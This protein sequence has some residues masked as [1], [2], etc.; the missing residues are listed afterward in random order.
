[1]H[2]RWHTL[3]TG[4][5]LF[6]FEYTPDSAKGI[7]DSCWTELIWSPIHH[8]LQDAFVRNQDLFNTMFLWSDQFD[9]YVVLADGSLECCCPCTESRL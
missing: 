3:A 9:V 5:S 8:P 1:M 4:K 6:F 7:R 2:H